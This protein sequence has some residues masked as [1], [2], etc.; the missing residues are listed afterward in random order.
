MATVARL[1]NHR[2]NFNFY[3]ENKKIKT[4]KIENGR[5]FPKSGLRQGCRGET[6]TPDAVWRCL[7][8]VRRAK[9]SCSIEHAVLSI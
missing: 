5:S 6:A 9:R 8:L 3:R 4:C 7:F 2:Y 1:T